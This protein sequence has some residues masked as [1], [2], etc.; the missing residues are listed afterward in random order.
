MAGLFSEEAK[1]EKNRKLDRKANSF[2]KAHGMNPLEIK[3]M[4]LNN[5]EGYKQELDRLA[6]SNINHP[7]RF[8]AGVAENLDQKGMS[9]LGGMK[10]YAIP[11]PNAIS[12]RLPENFKNTQIWGGMQSDVNRYTQ[13]LSNDFNKSIGYNLHGKGVES[14]YGHTLAQA[15]MATKGAQLADFGRNLMP[16]GASARESFL[17]SMGF[18]GRD[19]KLLAAKS[20]GIMENLNRRVLA[21]AFG[22][23]MAAG[24]ADSDTPLAD[25]ATGVTVGAG[26]QQ[27]WRAGKSFGNVLGPSHL[28]R[29]GFGGLGAAA[30]AAAPA[31]VILGQSDMFKN[32][33]FVAKKAKSVYSRESFAMTQDTQASLTMRRAGLEKLSSSYLNNRQQLLGNEASILRGSQI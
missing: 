1:Q 4:M 23:F 5:P 22:L 28:K 18:T 21:P 24:A 16:L 3:E 31:A 6:T 12:K 15:K 26:L 10:R 8:Q 11:L 7:D 27:G 14:G 20:G 33:S 13:M 29:L 30:M 19:S 2:A 17:M 9:N 32:D 25:Y